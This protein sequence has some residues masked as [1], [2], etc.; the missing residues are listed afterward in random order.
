MEAF[1]AKSIAVQAPTIMSPD[2]TSRWRIVPG[3]GVEHSTDGG[4]TWQLQSTGVATTPT[5]GAAP[6]AA[7]C[8]LVGPGGLV[9]LTIDGRTWTPVSAPD[10]IDLTAV[11]ASDAANATV[12]AA[13]G[14]TFVTSDG[15]KT[16]RR[17][18]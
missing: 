2:P 5:A 15:G 13:D 9:L 10:T 18:D 11:R 1:A 3:I 14:R 17:I 6:A 4:A 16:W 8:W 12:T 7:I